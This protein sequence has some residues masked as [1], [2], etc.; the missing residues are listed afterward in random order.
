MEP[1]EYDLIA[2]LEERH[3]WY[4]GMRLSARALLRQ[5]LSLEPH[6]H[7][8][9]GLDILDA[10][11][12]TGG[13]LRWLA[14]FG[15][16][17]GL[18]FH[19]RAVQLAR[20]V[21][22]RVTRASVLA[23]PFPAHR[24]DLVTSFDV[25]YHRAVI[26]DALALREFARVLRPGGWLLVRV[27]AHDR[28]RGAHDVQVHTRHRYA[29]A[30]LGAKVTGAG[31][32]VC[33]L[34]YAGSFLLPPALLRRRLQRQAVAEAAAHSDVSLPPL[35]INALLRTAMHFESLWLRRWNIPAGLSL[36]VLARKPT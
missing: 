9:R 36:I 18:D 35:P 7:Q 32:Q 16:V 13:G 4:T 23:L 30:E 34:T 19:P 26:D 17:T 29:R 5:A 27:P 31:L 24:F 10:G 15:A 1:G 2:A 28:L 11:C 22:P 14:E 12:G 21:S 25:L 20:R 6:A 33:R 3:W 8:P